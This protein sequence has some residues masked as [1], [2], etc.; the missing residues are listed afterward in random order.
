MKQP[1]NLVFDL[2][3]LC[4]AILPEKQTWSIE[5]IYNELY[6]ASEIE[7]EEAIENLKKIL[8]DLERKGAVIFVNGFESIK[9]IEP[10]LLELA[11]IPELDDK[12]NLNR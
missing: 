2:G 12:N 11:K 8:K 5:D 10:K 6:G 1:N 7:K 9:L 3:K 4:S